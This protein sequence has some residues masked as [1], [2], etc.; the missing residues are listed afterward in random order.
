MAAI[1]FHGITA[2]AATPESDNAPAKSSFEVPVSF[3]LLSKS[4][5]G[6][7]TDM[8]WLEAKAAEKTLTPM[9]AIRNIILVLR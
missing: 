7:I 1:T 8:A 3:R 9:A 6:S 4:L 2:A 5:A